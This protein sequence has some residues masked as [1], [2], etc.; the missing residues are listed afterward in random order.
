MEIKKS[1]NDN[2]YSVSSDGKFVGHVC[3]YDAW[4]VRGTRKTWDAIQKG[5]IIE[6]GFTTRL[7]A[8]AFLISSNKEM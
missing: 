8:A 5:R 2:T 7:K 6:T 4:T 3:R 1:L